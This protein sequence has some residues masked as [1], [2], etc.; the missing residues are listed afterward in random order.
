M[1]RFVPVTVLVLLAASRVAG[2]DDTMPTGPLASGASITFSELQIHEDNNPDLDFPEIT[3]DSSW[4][5]F[6]LAHCQCTAPGAMPSA[7]F[8]EKT[9]AFLLK[10]EGAAGQSVSR[11]LELWVGT[12]CNTDA[13]RPPSTTATCRQVGSIGSVDELVSPGN[14]R[15]EIPIFEFM[16][17]RPTDMACLAAEQSST[18]WALVDT[19]MNNVPDYSNS[20]TITTDSAPPPPPSGFSAA[21]GDKNIV[22]SWDPPA[23]ASDVYGYQVLCSRADSG[24]DVPGKASGRP[25]R[26]YMTAQLLCDTPTPLELAAI[27]VSIPSD[28]TDTRGVMLSDGLKNLDPTFLCGETLDPVA[29]SLQITG[30]E[31]GVPYKIVLLEVD[32]F[33]NA[34]GMFLTSTVTPVETIDFWEDI[35]EDSNIEGGLCL[36]AETYGDDSALTTA[37]R[38]FRDDTLGRTRIGRWVT[39]A[40]YATLGKLGGPVHGSLALRIVAGVVLA[41]LVALA[42]AWHWLTLPGLL[43]ALGLAWLWRRRRTRRLP[44]WLARVSPLAAAL[45]VIFA[46]GR[47]HAGG[48]QPYWENSN[49]KEDEQSLADE[50]GDVTWH[51]GI[52]VGPYVP[53]IDK[54]FSRSPGPYEQMFGGYRILPMLDV[55]RILWSRLGQVGVGLSIGYLQKSARTFRLDSMP[56]DDPRARGADRN[57]FRLVPMALTATYRFTWFDDEYGVPVVPY[58]RGGLSYYLWWVSVNGGV[59]EVCNDLMSEDPMCSKNKALGA[60]VGVQ[61]S[62]G[63]AIRAERI[64]GPTAMSMQQSGIQHAGI[65]A[66]L[67]LAKVDGFGS[68]TKLSVGDATWFAGVNFEF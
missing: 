14:A 45:A 25:Q 53:D 60:S 7:D 40:Y 36:L 2:A 39:A 47:A 57:K 61:G 12:A 48:Y 52:R 31:N 18:L 38:A 64:D 10:L 16:T 26:R 3:P 29:D 28:S 51:V 65:Y 23:D 59:A 37:L 27:D 66:E 34:W 32:K 33:Q 62:I 54:Q 50:P 5:Y 4:H 30:L 22:I 46:A 49:I 56:S 20:T 1:T 58:V 24:T 6:N 8:N 68:D 44:R 43:A 42:L 35:H 17:P 21:G 55:D 13:A 11:P 63:I 41:P 19:N 67:S 9:F 15:P